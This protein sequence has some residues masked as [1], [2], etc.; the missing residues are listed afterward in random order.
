MSD[1]YTEDLPACI[2]FLN[3]AYYNV[4]VR[5]KIR[6]MAA[7][8]GVFRIF[9]Q[10]LTTARLDMPQPTSPI[11]DTGPVNR[12]FHVVTHTQDVSPRRLR[13]YYRYLIRQQNARRSDLGMTIHKVQ[14]PK[15]H[16]T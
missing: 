12:K 5:D 4:W 3:S 11:T 15:E 16:V 6:T 1:P 2:Q 14:V 9:P 7:D 8:T 13:V 10:P